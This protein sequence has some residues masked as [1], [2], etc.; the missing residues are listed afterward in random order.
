[1]NV[2]ARFAPRLQ[3]AIVSRLGWRS[4]SVGCGFLHWQQIAKERRM[5]SA[6]TRWVLMLAIAP[7]AEPA[8]SAPAETTLAT[9]LGGSL[10]TYEAP[11]PVMVFAIAYDEKCGGGGLGVRST[12][13]ADTSSYNQARKTLEES[14]KKEYPQA[15]G[16]RAGSS[17]FEFGDSAGAVTIISI[18]SG[19][20]AC[21][22]SAIVVSPR[23]P[24]CGARVLGSARPLAANEQ[25][26]DDVPCDR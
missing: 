20:P 15:K 8:N 1:V 25:R 11:K 17:F 4:L 5:Y 23:A 3:Q 26:S 6:L 7:T 24:R 12:A 19:T 16:I 9:F 22:S 2:F 10:F 13:M 14:M 21:P 18:E